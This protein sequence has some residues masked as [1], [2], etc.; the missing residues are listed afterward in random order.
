MSQPWSISRRSFLALSG[1]AIATCALPAIAQSTQPST[2]PVNVDQRY[3]IS[4]CDWMILKRQKLG[5]VKLAAECGCDGVEVDLGSVG[6]APDMDNKLREETVRKQY[7]DE[8][9]K[10]G[11]A[12]SSLALSGFYAQSVAEHPRTVDYG[13]EML[14]QASKM[15]VKV[16]FLPFAGKTDLTDAATRAKV[17]ERMKAIAAKAE[18]LD[19]VL[20]VSANQAADLTVKL[21]DDIGSPIVRAYYNTGDAVEA[22]RDVVAELKL[23][24]KE[25]ICQIHLTGPDVALLQNGPLD[26]PAVKAALDKIGYRGWLVLERARDPKKVKDVKGNYS[27]N[28]AYLKSIFQA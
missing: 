19:V 12:I 1:A 15:G 22:K 7:L 6:Q 23:L 21:L 8:A 3:R 11:I 2:K 26:V 14:E 18:K 4:V 9:A 20:G 28:A 25:R 17:V 24:G 27:A 13:V 10:F 5:A 16:G